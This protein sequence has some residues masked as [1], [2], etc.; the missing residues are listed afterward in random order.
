MP[1]PSIPSLRSSF[2]LPVRPPLQGLY[3]LQTEGAEL[4]GVDGA[5]RF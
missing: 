2:S 1:D 4:S 3:R 5:A